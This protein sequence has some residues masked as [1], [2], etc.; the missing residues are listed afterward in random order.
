M[1]I[2]PNSTIILLHNCPLDK[3]Y[4]HTLT[5][6]SALAQQNYFKSLAKYTFNDQSYTRYQ[7]GVLTIQK[8][9]ED[10]YDCNYLMFQN[11]SFGNKWFYA[12][13]TA[14]DYVNNV[15]SRVSLRLMLCRHGNSIIP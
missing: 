1:Y 13:V 9:A 2:A 15:T 10:L 11:T 3:T 5:F 4:D 12:F 6:T 8:K 7:R 14:I